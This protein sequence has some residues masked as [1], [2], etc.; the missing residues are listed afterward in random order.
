MKKL[1]RI[2]VK[3]ITADF[4]L[5]SGWGLISPIFAI[6]IVNSIEGGSL[7]MVGFAAAIY[8][9]VKSSLQPFLV[10]FLGIVRGEKDDFNFLIFGLYITSLVPLGYFFS[11]YIWHIFLLEIIRGISMACVVPAWHGIFTR[12]INKGWEAFSWSVQSTNFGFAFGFAAAF[13][14]ILASFLGFRAVFIMVSL[15]GMISATL[16]LIIKN[17]TFPKK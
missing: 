13:G 4:F 12:H 6:F 15:L 3:L 10:N 8:W 7:E 9:I 14:G 11:T 5:H 2:I 1:S 16:I 17:Q